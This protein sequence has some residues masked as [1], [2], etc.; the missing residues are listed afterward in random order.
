[1]K[2]LIMI[3]MSMALG[4]GSTLLVQT[5][6]VQPPPVVMVACPD[7]DPSLVEQV[8]MEKALEPLGGTYVPQG[9][10]LPPPRTGRED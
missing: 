9:R 3:L 4:V 8:I 7:P 10:L 5:V 6:I 2:T 1:M